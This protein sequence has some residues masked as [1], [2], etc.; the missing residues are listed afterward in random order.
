MRYAPGYALAVQRRPAMKKR[1]SSQKSQKVTVKTKGAQERVTIGMDL[2]D[3]TSRYC[4]LGNEGEIL[5]EGQVATTKTGI[6][7]AF[8]SLVRARI[9]TEIGNH[10]PWQRQCRL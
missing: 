5:R 6:E 3:K 8:G 9:A 4:M 7:E 2:G 10:S 1:R